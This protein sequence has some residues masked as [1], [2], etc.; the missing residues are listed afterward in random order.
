MPKKSVRNSLPNPRE[1]KR[2][3]KLR[4]SLFSVLLFVFTTRMERY[5][6]GFCKYNGSV[7]WEG[8]GGSIFIGE[9]ERDT[10]WLKRLHKSKTLDG[11]WWNKRRR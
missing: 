6:R 7:M 10:D 2:T 8:E 5:T 9:R 11:L 4:F 3:E 1:M